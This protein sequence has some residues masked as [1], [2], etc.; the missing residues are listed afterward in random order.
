L[1]KLLTEYEDIFSG[2][3]ED[4]GRT[5]KVYH[6]IDTGDARTIRRPPRRIRLAKQA[7]I[8]E[9]LDDMQRHGVIEESDSPWSSPIVLARKKNGEIHFCV[10]YRK[11]NDV[12]KKDCF[13]LPR[14]D[15]TLDTLAGAKWFSTL[16]LKSGYWQVDVHPDDKE[17][18][19]FSTGQGLWQFTV[20]PFGLCNAPATFERLMETV[21]RGLTYDS[22]LVYLDD[23]IVIGS[24][25]QGHLLNLRKV[26][27][28]FREA[29]LKLNPEKC[30]LLQKKVKYLGHV[31]SPEGI[32]TDPKKL[33]A[34]REWPT[35]KDKHEIRSFLGLCTYYR[36]F[37]S[38]FANIA[39]PLTKLTEQK[40]AFQWTPE[41]EAGFQTL[42]GALCAAPILAYPKPGERF[43]V[44][45]DASNF[46]IGGV[47]SHM[48][49]G[50][51][52]VIAYYI[53]MLNKA[54]RNYCVTRRE[55]L[56]T[57]RTL[58]HFH[59]YLYGQQFHLR[60]DHSALT[61]L[62]SFRNLE[63]QTARWIQ[64]LQEYNFTSEHRQGRKHNNADALS[65]RPCQE[66][67]MHCNNVEMRADVKQVRAI[68]ALPAVG[69][70][71]LTLRTEQLNDPDIG[72]ILQEAETGQRPEWKDIAD[73]SPTY[74]SY[75]AQWNSLSVTNG[76]LERNWESTNGRSKTAQIVIPRS[77]VQDVLTELHGG[78]SGG[79][80]GVNKTLNKVRQRFYWLQARAD[81]EKWCRQC[82]TC[83]ASRGPRT[84]N[85]G[86]MH[87]YNV[88][89]PFER[90]A[91]DVAGPFPR[92][93]QGN[94]YLLIAMD[95][96]TK[97]P[98]VYAIPNQE[99][100]Q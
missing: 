73:R 43:I 54:E 100:Q 95:Y 37:I 97:W 84:R 98:E 15:E 5:N 35:P 66:E 20:M 40:Q 74:K 45:T 71:P 62:M 68:A 61:W 78:P 4:Y 7:E 1:R 36:R 11:L 14:I 99:R 41:V 75:W 39:K 18:T 22:C 77:R 89:A 56:A 59:K 72:P 50:Q 87:Q 49:D 30:Q 55:L 90:I 88:G 80:L 70:D 94:R 58:E 25:F 13:S 85:R 48:Q 9:M 63:G 93:N 53:K 6:R 91:I 57:V 44:D 79:H 27:E 23:V 52:R 16:D 12:R 32:S 76:I 83:A 33:K 34:V 17:K 69:W 19:A 60:T 92:S 38:G 86:Q 2:D 42:K 21:L 26:F 3:D 82:D 10:D 67:S 28:R 29:R 8:K 64:C 47:L 65:R 24:T 51:E 31:V 96:F 46:G 81:V